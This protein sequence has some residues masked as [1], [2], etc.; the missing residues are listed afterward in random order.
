LETPGCFEGLHPKSLLK[1][2]ILKN[3]WVFIKFANHHL[4]LH[5]HSPTLQMGKIV[6][7]NVVS[8]AGISYYLIS[9]LQSHG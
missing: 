2:W 4:L 6:V 8:W 5:H 3:I 7:K 1:Y 9:L